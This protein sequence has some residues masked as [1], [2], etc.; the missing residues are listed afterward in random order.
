LTTQV[1]DAHHALRE[2]AESPVVPFRFKRPLI[3]NFLYE[4]ISTERLLPVMTAYDKIRVHAIAI[5]KPLTEPPKKIVLERRHVA[6]VEA[7]VCSCLSDTHVLVGVPKE[8]PHTRWKFGFSK[9]G[10]RR[11]AYDKEKK[12][13]KS[14][15]T[16]SS[17][18][19]FAKK[20][21][22]SK[23]TTSAPASFAAGAD[24]TPL[25]LPS[26]VSVY[27]R[28]VAY[29]DEPVRMGLHPSAVL[30]YVPLHRVDDRREEAASQVPPEHLSRQPSVREGWHLAG[31]AGLEARCAEV[32]GR[33]L[34]RTRENERGERERERSD[35]VSDGC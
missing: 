30:A 19:S 5:S 11:V 18:A 26:D 28:L 29:G 6:A 17:P 15:K 32:S 13:G 4:K 35:A 2:V 33:G 16:T 8:G 34:G 27:D 3:V 10:L 12:G 21:R 25:D 20:G 31:T 9:G 14:K 22:K 23:K 7:P 1:L 24:V